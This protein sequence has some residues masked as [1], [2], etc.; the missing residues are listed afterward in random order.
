MKTNSEETRDKIRSFREGVSD[1]VCNLTDDIVMNCE[2][3]GSINTTLAYK[4]LSTF[5][6]AM[7][8]ELQG[9]IDSI[10]IVDVENVNKCLDSMTNSAQELRYASLDKQVG[11]EVAKRVDSIY[12]DSIIAKKELGVI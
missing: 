3:N 6:K 9:L 5:R 11:K 2:V 1:N 10:P 8:T 7:L 12:D 4:Y